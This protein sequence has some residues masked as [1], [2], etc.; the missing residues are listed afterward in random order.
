MSANTE[1]NPVVEMMQAALGKNFRDISPAP[2]GRWLAGTLREVKAGSLTVEFTI[3]NEMLNPAGTF[4]GGVIA[5]IMD[6]TIGATILSLAEQKPYTS[7]N[8]VVDFFAPAVEGAVVFARTE[9]VKRG[10]TIINVQCEIRD[11]AHNHRLIA[12]GYS[13]MMKIQKDLESKGS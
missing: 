9:V 7:V 11:T 12:R 10:S 3:R 8:L 1:S 6:D 5:A 13:N 4:H 2:F